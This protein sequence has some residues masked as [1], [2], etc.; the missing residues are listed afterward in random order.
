MER[1]RAR[2]TRMFW[3]VT[4]TAGLFFGLDVALHELGTVVKVPFGT[5]RGWGIA[6]LIL[7]VA[8]GVALPI[9]L[10]AQFQ[11][12]AAR[13]RRVTLVQYE[14][15]QIRIM[16]L[17]WAA[18]LAADLAYLFPVPPVYLYGSVLAGLYGIYSIIPSQRKI[19]AELRYYGLE[20]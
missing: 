12:R 15:L 17:A 13:L 16:L 2:L 18:A 9:L 4:A 7:A 3:I 19:T 14:A 11:T 20:Q 6:L 5:L 10:R 8:C 1:V